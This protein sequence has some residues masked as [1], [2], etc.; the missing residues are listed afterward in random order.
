M[1]FQMLCAY[2]SDLMHKLFINAPVVK[3]CVD[4]NAP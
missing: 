2:D 3:T 1:A 4:S